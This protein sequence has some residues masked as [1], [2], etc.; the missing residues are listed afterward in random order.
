MALSE[1]CR[2]Q[3]ENAGTRAEIL[4][5]KEGFNEVLVAGEPERRVEEQRRERG[6]PIGHGTWHALCEAADRLGVAVPNQPN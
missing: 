1:V 2:K 5:R 6:I 4:L 3:L